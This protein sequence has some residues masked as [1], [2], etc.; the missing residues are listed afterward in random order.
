MYCRAGQSQAIVRLVLAVANNLTIKI[1]HG[2][3]FE[4]VQK[5]DAVIE[6]RRESHD[7]P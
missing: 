5:S 6:N 4:H 3:V 7:Q 2:E 1:S